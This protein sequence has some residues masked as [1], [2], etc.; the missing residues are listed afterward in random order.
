WRFSD[1]KIL[2][3]SIL[4]NIYSIYFTL[5]NCTQRVLTSN[6]SLEAWV[7]QNA[8]V[9]N[10]TIIS[11]GDAK[12]SNLRGYHLFLNSGYPNLSWYNNS[13]REILN[14]A[15]PY[16]ITNGANAKWHHIAA[17]YDGANAKLYIDGVIVANKSTATPPTTGTEKFLMG[18][19][20]TSVSGPSDTANNFDGYIDEVRIWD[21]A[22]TAQQIHEM[23]NQEI[24]INA[25]TGKVIGKTIP[26]DITGGLTWINLKAYY[27]MND[28][29][30]NDKSNNGTKNGLSKNMTTV[31]SQTA[32]L[33]YKSALDGAW[34]NPGTWLNGTVQNLPISTG[35]DNSTKIEWSIIQIA[36]TITSGA[37]DITVLGLIS[38]A[39]KLT[40][41]GTTNISTGT[42]IGQSLRVTNY[43]KLDGVIDLAGESQLLQ[44]TGSILDQVSAG[45]IERDQYGQA[46]KYN[47]NYWGS[48]VGAINTTTNN[49]NFTVAGVL[50]D[51]T[52]PASPA[53]ITWIAGYDGTTTPFSLARYWIYKFDN[54]AN[55][56][57]NWTQ[58]GETGSLEAGKG[59]T[60]KGAGTSGT[61][62]LTFT[63]KPNNGTITNAIGANQLLLVGNPY[64][65]AL[66]ADLFITDNI[67]SINTSVTDPAIDGALYFW[68]Q[69][70][71]NTTHILG[72]YQGGYGIRN[73]SGG[74]APSAT[75]VDFISGTG[76]TSKLA[77]KQ[78]IPVGQGFFVIGKTVTGGNVTFK[79]SQRAFVKEDNAASQTMYK[80]P[81]KPKGLNQLTNNSDDPIKKDTH[82]RIRLG[83]TIYNQSFHRQVLLAFMD[84]KANSEMNNGYDAFNIDDFP[85]DMYLLNGENELAIEGEGFFDTS[86]SYPIGV[87]TD[88]EGKVSFM[89]DALENFDS[90]QA[91]FIYD[92]VT[93]TYHN[94]KNGVFKIVLPI[95]VYDTRFSLR[96]KDKTLKIEKNS[97]NDIQI[98]FNQKGNIL[99][100]NNKLLDVTVEKVTLFNILGQSISSLN[101]ENQEQQNIQV[102]IKNIS[103]GIYIAKLKTSKGELSKKIIV[104]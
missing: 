12:A 11:K 100:I 31:Q 35:I 15:S 33:P 26:I 102:P 71:T 93:D 37:K 98:S 46:N 75:G 81:P 14:I 85:S 29:T 39:G 19:M 27:P 96:F 56:Y 28:N 57:A 40:I 22:L 60:L 72:S 18:T 77:P 3:F 86:A 92:N 74:L 9:T 36:H 79:N 63:G 59:F 103:S 55:A 48:P 101:I 87:K 38:T 23:M 91:I 8:T 78:Y 84:E 16:A 69:F 58:I 7:L 94:L 51:G 67:G 90:E 65:S 89:I 61:E 83:Y 42:G 44:D 47:Y 43:L 73:L 104:H 30:V 53:T 41:D 50:R 64:P 13:G 70:A 88:V 25:V 97:I 5:N 24:Q 49:N 20:Y 32:P 34:D 66:D 80:S 4:T 82:K 21:V 62:N 76:A 45:Y 2:N 10:G 99:A 68:E 1:F 54:K 95:G 52:N 6:F 17:T